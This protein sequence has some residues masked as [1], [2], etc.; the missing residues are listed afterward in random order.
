MNYKGKNAITKNV[1]KLKCNTIRKWFF[2]LKFELIY[3]AVF[4]FDLRYI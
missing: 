3:K 4:E 2:S 1:I